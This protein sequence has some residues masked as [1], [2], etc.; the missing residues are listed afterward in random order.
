M[1][2]WADLK[3]EDIEKY[4]AQI[5]EA[6]NEKLKKVHHDSDVGEKSDP[7]DL[8]VDEE[9]KTSDSPEGSDTQK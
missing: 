5:M 7:V 8:P 9:E 4:E 1:D 3:L 6:L 2:E